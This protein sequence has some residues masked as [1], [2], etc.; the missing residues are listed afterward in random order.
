MRAT[1]RSLARGPRSEGGEKVSTRPTSNQEDDALKDMEFVPSRT[2]ACCRAF[3][4]GNGL[5]SKSL[6]G[7]EPRRECH[8]VGKQS[9]IGKDW[10]AAY[11]S[12]SRAIPKEEGDKRMV[13]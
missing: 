3:V 8:H 13:W 7:R 11:R 4:H 9:L 2:T 5:G 12:P 6:S 10:L 1:G